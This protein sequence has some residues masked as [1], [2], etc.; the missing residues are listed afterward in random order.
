MSN[1]HDANAAHLSGQAVAAAHWDQKYTD[2]ISSAWTKNSLVERELYMRMTGSP[3]HWLDWTFRSY[4]PPIG[5]LLSIGC[6]DG[7]HE[8]AIVRHG[9]AGHVT[10]FDA[11]PVAIAHAKSAAASEG[12]TNVDYRVSTFEEFAR[13]PS[14]EQFDAV[15]MSGSLHH[16]TEIEALLFAVRRRLKP[17]APIIVNEYVGPCYQLYGAKQVDIV[18]RTLNAIPDEFKIAPGAQLTLPTIEMIMAGDP[19]EGV[20]ASLIRTLLPMFFNVAYERLIGGALLHPIF[21]YLNDHRI[22]DG[23]AESDMLARMLIAADSE[24]TT[25]GALDHDFLFGIYTNP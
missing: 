3:G 25:A 5:R 1:T 23:S 17:S 16:V 20:R 12:L 21:G 7:S 6:G 18:N 9:F 8:L 22:N 24:L 14:G 13:D 10:A 4:L 15:L 2:A 19:T 11:S